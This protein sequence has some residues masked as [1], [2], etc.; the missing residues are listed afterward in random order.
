MT[1]L[2]AISGSSAY[3]SVTSAAF[4][5]I[6]ASFGYDGATRLMNKFEIDDPMNYAQINGV[7]GAWGL[8]AIGIFHNKNGLVTTASLNLL[9]KQIVYCL[10]AVGFAVITSVSLWKT[11]KLFRL[12]IDH[13]FEVIGIDMQTNSKDG[14]TSHKHQKTEQRNT[15]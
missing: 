9:F 15:K 10:A 8:I 13:I 2:A 3:V 12:R 1:S 6:I 5:G 7:G 11:L 14:K 4:I